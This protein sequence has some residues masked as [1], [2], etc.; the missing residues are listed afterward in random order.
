[1]DRVDPRNDSEMVGIVFNDT[2]S[3]R[4]KFS[5]GHRVPIMRENFEYS[6]NHRELVAVIL[7]AS[8]SPLWEVPDGNV[9]KVKKRS[10]VLF[11]SELQGVFI[12][13]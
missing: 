6:G 3:Y 5:W 8:S 2:F 4:L 12:T 11:I 7:A 10:I 13:G 1:M 9:N